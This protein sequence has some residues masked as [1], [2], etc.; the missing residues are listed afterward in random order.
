M[1]LSVERSDERTKIMQGSSSYYIFPFSA[2]S[3]LTILKSS[4][5]AG[6]TNKVLED[7][8]IVLCLLC[9]LSLFCTP[10]ATGGHIQKVTYSFHLN[11][12][13]AS[14]RP[15]RQIRLNQKVFT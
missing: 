14:I 10:G 7:G 4:K 11:V 13:T 6:A 9:V 2:D 12:S 15:S 5:T 1:P 3:L 8:S